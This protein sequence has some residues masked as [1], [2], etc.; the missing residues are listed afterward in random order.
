LTLPPL[1]PNPFK[2]VDFHR[3]ARYSDAVQ[4]SVQRE[5]AGLGDAATDLSQL[6]ACVA[7]VPTALWIAKAEQIPTVLEEALRAATEQQATTGRRV[8][9]A[10]VVYDLPGRDCGASASSGEISIADGLST[11]ESLY[12]RPMEAVLRRWPEP[13]KAFFLEPDSLPN[14][15]TSLGVPKCAAAAK[16]YRSGVARAADLLAPHGALYLDVGNSGWIGSGKAQRMAEVLDDVLGRM[17][18]TAASAVR[19]IVTDVSNYASPQAEKAYAYSMLRE[20]SKLGHNGLHAVIDTSRGGVPDMRGQWCNAK[21]AGAGPRPTAET[22][23]GGRIDAYFWIKPPG[24]SDGTTDK[25]SARYDPACGKAGAMRHAPEAGQWFHDQFVM[26][27]QN[28]NPPF[29]PMPLPPQPIS[30]LTTST[31]TTTTTTTAEPSEPSSTPSAQPNEV[32]LRGYDSGCHLA[33]RQ[34]LPTGRSCPSVRSDPDACNTA[35]L[36]HNIHRDMQLCAFDTAA[37]K[38]KKVAGSSVPCE[39]PPSSP[40]A[41]LLPVARG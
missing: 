24:E 32:D 35:F 7:D 37:G 30:N 33:G 3:S 26:L 25:T 9:V 34:P 23:G 38:C 22:G 40:P 18:E 19:G 36:I 4:S 28:A 11:Y 31:T 27:V 6:L 21:G 41:P 1:D 10:I 16:G 14:L 8:L 17:A 15:V 39:H 29:E 5:G 2:N 13:R 20:L 12:L